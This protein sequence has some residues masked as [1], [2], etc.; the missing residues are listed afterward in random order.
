MSLD[1]GKMKFYAFYFTLKSNSMEKMNVSRQPVLLE[2]L[3]EL[4]NIVSYPY[5]RSKMVTLLG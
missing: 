1:L 4:R 3:L 5:S 2:A